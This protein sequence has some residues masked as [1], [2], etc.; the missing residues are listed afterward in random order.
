[1]GLMIGS[2]IFAS[3]GVVV[4]EVGSVGM[5]LVVWVLGGLLAMTGM[6]W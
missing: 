2:G 6:G 1:M 3:P 5:T 4:H